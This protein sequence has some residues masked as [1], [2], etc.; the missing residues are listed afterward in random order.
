MIKQMGLIE[1]GRSEAHLTLDKN[2]FKQGD[3]AT[4]KA[5]L[6]NSKCDKDL[7]EIFVQL[8]RSIDYLSSP[9]KVSNI[10]EAITEQRF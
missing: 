4:I 9:G 2:F 1:K 7:T 10:H 6:D 5:R 8:T 3:I